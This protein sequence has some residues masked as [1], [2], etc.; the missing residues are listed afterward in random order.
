MLQLLHQICQFTLAL[1]YSSVLLVLFR[2]Y[3][4]YASL[5][6][7]TQLAFGLHSL[8]EFT[9]ELLSFLINSGNAFL[10]GGHTASQ[11]VAFL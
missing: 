6:I 8:V 11:M 9:T 5:V 4:S 3:L 2:A 10:E 1:L 7:L